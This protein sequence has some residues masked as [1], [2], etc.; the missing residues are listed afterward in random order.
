MPLA[1]RHVRSLEEVIE[2]A[3]EFL[4]RPVDL[5]TRQQ[6]VV[7][8]AGAKAWLT[9]HLA[10]RLGIVANVEFSFPA[11][12]TALLQPSRGRDSDPW[13]FDRLTF[14]V[15]HLLTQPDADRLGIPFDIANA[16]LLT[17]RRIAALFDAYHVRRSG[18]I[19]EWE[20]DKPNP[21]LTPTA[22]DEVK[23]GHPVP[24]SLRESDRWQF[25]LW[26]A[27]RRHIDAPSP[28]ARM[29]LDQKREADQLLVAGLQTLSLQQLQCLELLGGVVDVEALLVHPSPGLH[30]RW[31]ASLP[32]PSPGKPPRR[33]QDPELPDGV[34]PLL[35]TWFTGS[36]ELQVLLAS[37][38]IDAIPPSLDADTS[39]PK[40]LLKRMQQT[41]ALGGEAEPGD[42]D[43]ATDHSV[44]IHRCHSLS[45]QAEVLH[46]AL[47]HAFHAI[48]GLEP[49]EVLIVS[50]CL[51]RAAPHLE[52]VL[53]RTMPGCESSGK[54][55]DL[56]LPFVIADRGIREASEAADL[57]TCLL[58]LSGARC[59][60]E[61]VLSV[62]RHTLVRQHFGIDENMVAMWGDLIERAGIR[63]GLDADHRSRHGLAVKG[64][65][66]VH[67]WK[68]GLERMLLGATLA[69]DEQSETIGGVVPLVALD[70]DDLR[71]IVPL[72]TIVDVI[73]EYEAAV[74]EHQ[75]VASWCRTIE[76][77]LVDL[78]GAEC[79]DLSEPLTL[80]RR[81]RD[82]ATGTAAQDT[83]V[84]FT[85]VREM[86][87]TWLDEK[88]GR[89]PLHTGV[90]T[91]TSMVPLRSVPFRVVCVFGYDDGAVGSGGEADG[92]D[93]VARQNLVGD[94]EPRT[95]ERRTLVDC[96]L[97]ARDRLII[98]CNGRSLKNNEPIPLV[99][100]LAE[101]VDFAVRH[102]VRREK[103]GAPS[104]IEV[105]QPRH[106]L[107]R[108][109]FLNGQV[110]P[111][112]TWSHDRVAAAVA[113]QIWSRTDHD[114]ATGFDADSAEAAGSTHVAAIEVTSLEALARDP[115]SL[116]IEQTLEIETWRRDEAATPAT[117]RL[118]ISKTATNKLS[119]ELLARLAKDPQAEGEWMKGVRSSGRLPFG[120]HGDAV[121]Q[122]IR[123]LAAGIQVMCQQKSVPLV[124][125]ESC[126]VSVDTRRSRVIGHVVGVHEPTRQI[127]HVTA[128]KGDRKSPGRPLHVAAVR[129]LVAKAAGLGVDKAS[130]VSR[131]NDWKPGAV[132]KAGN[133][134]P[135]CAIRTVTLAA[136][137]NPFERLAEVC[138]LV[139]EASQGPR[140]LFRLAE[141]NPGER[142][143]GFASF[144][145]GNWEPYYAD[146]LE[147]LVYG[148]TPSF[149]AVFAEGSAE[150]AFLD[151]YYRLLCLNRAFV[152]E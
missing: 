122:E 95:D 138:D 61:D 112:V 85:D 39:P 18:M 50:P 21:V 80:L 78:C 19:L 102:G 84:P 150:L 152:L 1:I 47:L 30:R 40:S 131:H 91:A 37:Q 118:S 71:T 82:A 44:V 60:E 121:E 143:E 26:R 8:T 144:V 89:Q 43:A 53:Q 35:A 11:A 90:I 15:L 64:V 139:I 59:G 41:V 67:T 87:L 113:P 63:W 127:V 24:D 72:I 98:T 57:L 22:N 9:S 100:P 141:K 111:G 140:G 17:A 128:G 83:P 126:E 142:V 104:G 133:P 132:T 20:R 13:S 27:V 77:A 6:I 58:T 14:A 123:E 81:L 10:E 31:V 74:V 2:P 88:A 3:V 16:P 130:V 146:S 23:D 33:V 62:A 116:Y 66:A 115:L 103:I 75:P 38:G 28:P 69:D 97:A 79:R 29:G 94:V 99:T 55:R 151:R 125:C 32:S 120:L 137:V 65:G 110:Q 70:P 4:S 105:A 107:G 119:L 135:P 76:R 25:D 73:R 108:R 134:V 49:H 101:F 56:K 36:H 96:L 136:H 42:H 117:F 5:F 148:L 92:D 54:K 46:D 48:P 34:D 68:L 106:H 114:D 109:N 12:I 51:E 129:L 147:A 86:L 52:A 149:D 7:P 145:N 93:L 124:G 45:R